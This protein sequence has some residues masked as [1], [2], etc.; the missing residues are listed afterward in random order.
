M[1]KESKSFFQ[2]YPIFGHVMLWHSIYERITM[3]TSISIVLLAFLLSVPLTS[4]A[5]ANGT[6]KSNTLPSQQK[7][8]SV[9][10]CKC[11]PPCECSQEDPCPIGCPCPEGFVGGALE[12]CYTP[13]R[14]E[15]CEVTC[16]FNNG[17]YVGGQIGYLN[18]KHRYNVNLNGITTGNFS[19]TKNQSTVLGG[20]L[21]GGRY[22]VY[23]QFFVG[24]EVG[25]NKDAS[26]TGF[27]VTGIFGDTYLHKCKRQYNIVPTAVFGVTFA[28]AFATY[29]KLG[30]DISKYRFSMT[31]FDGTVTPVHHKIKTVFMPAIGVEYCFS[32]SL[33]TRIEA[34]YNFTAQKMATNDT[35][36]LGFTDRWSVKTQNTLVT[37]GLLF[38]F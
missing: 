1:L 13:S 23:P 21:L 12:P 29:A 24:A 20:V 11:P 34:S 7:K 32:P 17:F 25:V 10:K 28:Q 19:K 37:L 38:K 8:Q 4:N 30:V 2:F 33:S 36:I 15:P 5:L 27:M 35:M 3:K 31:S 14:E 22:F 26:S 6:I 18:A 16:C 9:K